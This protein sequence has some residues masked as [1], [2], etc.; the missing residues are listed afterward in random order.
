MVPCVQPP[1]QLI[2]PNVTEQRGDIVVDLGTQL[3]V[4]LL[5][6]ETTEAETVNDTQCGGVNARPE[7][8]RSCTGA[9]PVCPYLWSYTAWSSVS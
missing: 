6:N 3:E 2:I 1:V 8:T 4:V 9:M 7:D 5:R